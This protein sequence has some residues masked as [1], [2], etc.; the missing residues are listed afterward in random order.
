MRILLAVLFL[1]L[2][3]CED[4]RIPLS[5]ARVN[6]IAD[7]KLE[8]MAKDWGRSRETVAPDEVDDRGR[9]YWCV[10]YPRGPH[11]EIR[12]VYV[13][14]ATSWATIREAMPEEFAQAGEDIPTELVRARPVEVM[15]Q[16]RIAAGSSILI[17]AAGG[18]KASYEA[19]V[20]RL[21]ELGKNSGLVPAFSVRTL[22]TRGYQL[23][24]GWN[25]EHGIKPLTGITDWLSVHAP[26]YADVYW[27]DLLGDD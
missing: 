6:S 9:R 20:R 23:I 17:L 8:L 12:L 10:H 3:G 1:V 4:P 15:E 24:Y 14:D 2:L 25:G 16:L 26:N 21:N 7:M 13:N 18:D 27:L 19:E 11:G 5:E 22:P